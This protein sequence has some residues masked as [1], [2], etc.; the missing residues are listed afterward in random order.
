MLAGPTPGAEFPLDSSARRSAAPRT[1]P[2]R[3]TTT[4]CRAFTAR[5]TRSAKVATRSSTRAR[6]TACASTAPI[7]A[8]ASSSR[9][10]SSSSATCASASSARA[11][12]SCPAW[13]TASSSR[14]SPIGR[15][16]RCA[17][18]GEPSSSLLAVRHR[19]RGRRDRSSSA[20]LRV[21][22]DSSRRRR[23]HRHPARPRRPTIP[24]QLA[25]AGGEE[26]LRRG[27]VRSRARPP[28]RED[29]QRSRRSARARDYQNI[30]T[31][32]ADG[33]AR[34]G[35]QG[36]R[37]REEAP[38]AP[39]RAADRTR[40][41]RPRR[42]IAAA[43]LAELDAAT[44]ATASATTT[45]DARRDAHVDRSA[46]TPRRR[47]RR[48][49]R[50]PDRA[51]VT[52]TSPPVGRRKRLQSGECARDE[53]RQRRRARARSSRASSAAARRRPTRCN[54]LK[55]ICKSQH[56]KKLHRGDRREVPAVACA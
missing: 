10:T 37:R 45:T 40:C 27:Q 20:D 19:R 2:S 11:R 35:R 1:A 32:W 46:R 24:E 36:D 29:R 22:A 3:S 54:L 25:L 34:A 21:H 49:P 15:R 39:R 4:R 30:E 44:S 13:V 28:R 8:A 48:A 26:G 16:R 12:S 43:K 52:H 23:R 53:R 47:P 18:R 38:H 41:R 56:D 6:R 51:T 42:N 14:R 7:C 9:A 55:G 50:P 5:C 33:D 17:R 31:R